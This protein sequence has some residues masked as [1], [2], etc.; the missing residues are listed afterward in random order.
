MRWSIFRLYEEGEALTA[1]DPN[2]LAGLG[3][4]LA[5]GAPQLSHDAH[6][7]QWLAG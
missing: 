4:C 1:D 7:S 6:V 3:T 2:S 5:A